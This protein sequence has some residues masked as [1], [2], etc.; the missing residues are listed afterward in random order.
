MRPVRCGISCRNASPTT[1]SDW[2]KPARSAFVESPSSRSTPRLPISASLP[3]SVRWPSTG[4]VV[5]LVVAGVDAEAAGRFEDDRG[6]VGDRV[7]HPDELEPERAEL[8]RVVV[9]RHLAQLR[10]AQQAVLVELRLDE[11][12]REAGR[13]HDRDAHLAHEV[14]EAADVVL[15]AV[16]EHDAA[17]HRLALAQVRD[18]GQ[19]EVDAEML[20]AREREAGVDDDDRAVGLVD[21]HVLADLAEAAE[22]DDPADAHRR[23]V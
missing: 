15:V 17:D 13:D 16:R 21:G 9:G 8:D 22:R 10:L 14:R 2:V 23:G 19:D 4:R 1:R 7:R 5:E 12:E 11:P 20:V 3:T 18:V 6:R